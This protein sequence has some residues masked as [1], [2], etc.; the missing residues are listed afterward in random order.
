MGHLKNPN[1]D[2]DVGPKKRLIEVH[3]QLCYLI[4]NEVSSSEE[5]SAQRTQ[6]ATYSD[7]ILLVY[8]VDSRASFDRAAELYAQVHNA[9]LRDEVFPNRH[10]VNP[11]GFPPGFPPASAEPVPSKGDRT[12][13]YVPVVLVG[14]KKDLGEPHREVSTVEG[15]T[16]AFDH[17]MG[18]MEITTHSLDDAKNLFIW[19]AS[20][21]LAG[22]RLPR[23]DERR[24]SAPA[25]STGSAIVS[26]VS[27]ALRNLFSRS[28]GGSS[29]GTSEVST[30]SSPV[31]R[32]T[33]MYRPVSEGVESAPQRALD[34]HNAGTQT[35]N[36]RRGSSFSTNANRRQV[37]RAYQYQQPTL[38]TPPRYVAYQQQGLRLPPRLT[39]P[40]ELQPA[41]R[42]QPGVDSANPRLNVDLG[43]PF[44]G[45]RAG[46]EKE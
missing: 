1:F 40:S 13:S 31:N 11:P 20:Q 7:I 6:L 41:P 37:G 10:G 12:I 35:G 21:A 28:E 9:R 3:G 18:Y 5:A 23:A 30:T 26:K 32:A 4:A 27:S 42:Q 2:D 29:S 19:A 43:T 24:A 8:S 25:R 45:A 15:K 17:D 14:N 22:H 34:Y 39:G 38:P 33:P 16:W 44:S 46:A 36:G